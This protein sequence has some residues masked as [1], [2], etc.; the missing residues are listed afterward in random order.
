M[1]LEPV[2]NARGSRQTG[3]N[4]ERT[5]DLDTPDVSAAKLS[6][7]E[8]HSIQRAARESCAGQVSIT[9]VGLDHEGTAEVS[10]A[11]IGSIERCS[12]QPT[13]TE[14]CVSSGGAVDVRF[15]QVGAT[16]AGVGQVCVLKPCGRKVRSLEVGT[17]K[18]GPSKFS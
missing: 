7:Y 18:N 4:D 12:K 1:G 8:E 2:E 10:R 3:S 6:V 17:T 9:E 11:E 5:G 16:K 13:H 14:V 15:G